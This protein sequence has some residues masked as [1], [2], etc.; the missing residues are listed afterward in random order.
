MKTCLK[1]LCACLGFLLPA[2]SVRAELT[3]DECQKLA[4]DNY[5]LLKR[6]CLI[7][8]T[9][10]FTVKNISRG[11]LPQ[12]TFTGQATVQSDVATLPGALQDMLNSN[13]YDYEGLRKDQYR[14]AVDLNQ[15]IYDGGNL[16]AQEEAAT[17]EGNAQAAKT[18]VD[19]YAVR[20]RVND[21][22][23]GLLLLEDKIKLNADLQTL[24]G[25]NCRKM[26]SKVRLGTAT[27]P[28]VDV[29]QAEL[30]KAQQDRTELEAMQS[31]FRLMLSIFTGKEASEIRD[32]ERPVADLPSLG[33]NR[34]PELRYYDAQINKANAQEKILDRSLRPRLSLF[35]QGYYG[36]TGYDMFHDMLSHKWTLNA[37]AGL[38]LTW[39]ISSFYTHKDEKRKIGLTRRQIET[40]RET[41][42][43]N[44]K[45][46]TTQESEDI[47]KYR[48]LLADDEEIIGL[49]TA[50]RQATE[51]KLE[52]GVADTNDLLAEITREN[53]A[54]TAHSTHQ[55]E[56]LKH[57]YELKYTINQ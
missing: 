45:L 30:K 24:L 7:E 25:D 32:L 13:G 14:L 4:Y 1:T 27:Q 23:F 31:S 37:M 16:K 22:F 9:T 38:R 57:I 8:Q 55:V 11:F 6:Y 56:M 18:D 54:R 33:E 42:L 3:L 29:L 12:L 50:V 48:K 53:Q 47:A 41:F 39:N 17:A 43:F 51:S 52:R 21:L 49:R 2:T 5:P 35:A 46:Q 36:Y 15:L 28:D 20:S 44:N 26:A 19:L 34:R 10:G 40:E